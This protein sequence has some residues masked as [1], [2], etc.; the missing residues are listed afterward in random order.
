MDKF[1]F[2]ES[3]TSGTG[4][5]FIKEVLNKGMEVIFLTKSPDKYLFL[6]QELIHP[7]DMDTDDLE[8]ICGFLKKIK[9]LKGILSTSEY[10]VEISSRAAQRFKLKHNNPSAINLCRN[11]GALYKYL[12]N[13]DMDVPKTAYVESFQQ[14]IS[15]LKKSKYPVV[16]KPN[17]LSGS[18]GVRLCQTY[19]EAISH[20]K[21]LFSNKNLSSLTDSK[22]LVLI[23]SYIDGEEYSVESITFDG[24]HT[25]IGI[26]KKYLSSPP[27]FLEIGHD[28]PG[29]KEDNPLAE[30]INQTVQKVLDYI[31]YNF[32][33]AHTEVRVNQGKV[34]IIEVNPRLA[35]G[36]IPLIIKAATGIDL[37]QNTIN[38]YLGQPLNFTPSFNRYSSIRYIIPQTEGIFK[39][40]KNLEDNPHITEYGMF[41]KIGDFVSINRDFRDRIGYLITEGKTQKQAIQK[42]TQALNG[43]ELSIQPH[44][45]DSVLRFQIHPQ[46]YQI[47]NKETN[48]RE[49]SKIKDFENFVIINEAHLLMLYKCQLLPKGYLQKIIIT[50]QKIK[51]ENFS[52]LI[53]KRAERGNYLL[54]E[55]HLI[56]ELGINIAGSIHTARSRND[57]L[58]TIF[59]INA[60]ESIL[61][62][63]AALWKLR[64]EVLRLAEKYKDKPFPIYSQYQTALPSNFAH[65]ILG[66][67]EA[68]SRD[69]LEYERLY[70]LINTSPLGSGA[71]NG[72]SLPIN[73]SIT[74]SFLGFEETFVNSLDAISNKDISLKIIAAIAIA[75]TNV[76]RIAADLQLWTTREFGFVDLPEILVG[77]SSLMPQKRNPYLLEEIKVKT[78][79]ILG[80]LTSLF[81]SVHK[82]PTGNSYEIKNVIVQNLQHAV[83]CFKDAL[84]LTTLHLKNAIFKW[85][86][87]NINS[88]NT[89][90]VSTYASELLT[91]SGIPSKKSHS[92]IAEILHNNSNPFQSIKSYLENENIL[93]QDNPINWAYANEYGGGPGKKSTEKQITRAQECLLND[94]V[95]W[96]NKSTKLQLASNERAIQLK[97][98]VN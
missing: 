5:H 30:L 47:L 6:N 64:S 63:Y 84:D 69:Q 35:G 95:W 77:G 93:L 82:T 87:V 42:V 20:L 11:K 29:L 38:L 34:Y 39:M 66:I 53:C 45:Q 55:Q 25:I 8:A 41:K 49:T 40:V 88:R 81:A 60:R 68:L 51:K 75:G 22:N 97:Q 26:T 91:L 92:I 58:E 21:F 76:S 37:I 27:H 71:G 17:N 2:I 94:A 24:Q 98:L 52:S 28:F 31:G 46:A 16:I 12:E 96:H 86:I 67:N 59:R 72:T 80:D 73:P 3:N 57:L 23:Q 78:T 90:L 79:Q 1:V 50:M 33:P 83:E 48:N 56:Q 89:L 74:A 32:G 62:I 15:F 36:M 85:D 19:Q 18:I 44:T 13:C 4:I 10:Y 9:R 65:Y 54:F 43:I 14:G 61:D 7:F 70:Q